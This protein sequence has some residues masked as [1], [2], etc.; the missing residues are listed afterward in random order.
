VKTILLF[1]IL[2]FTTKVYCQKV[3][4]KDLIG[5]WQQIFPK[6]SS[7]IEYLNFIDS[8][9]FYIL[10]IATPAVIKSNNDTIFNIYKLDTSTEYTTMQIGKE[11][12]DG[13]DHI[14]RTLILRKKGDNIL[15]VKFLRP[16][17]LPN[18]EDFPGDNR[19]YKRL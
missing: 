10:N 13:N 14:N 18:G 19:V 7:Y 8:S 12:K 17:W 6:R 9:H 15:F 16:D 1:T 4:Y 5:K 3:T 2:L 11:V